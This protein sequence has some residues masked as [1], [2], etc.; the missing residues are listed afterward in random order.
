MAF[1]NLMTP[2]L[3]LTLMAFVGGCDSELDETSNLAVIDA[4][5]C[6]EGTELNADGTQCVPVYDCFRGGFC[7]EAAVQG[8]FTE[9][10]GNIYARDTMASSGCETRPDS[11]SAGLQ[12]A[13][14]ASSAACVS[15]AALFFPQCASK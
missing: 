5:S 3:A 12:A 6:G 8:W 1:R 4:S 15:A 11:W 7:S 14:P 9:A 2:L 13:P 10:D